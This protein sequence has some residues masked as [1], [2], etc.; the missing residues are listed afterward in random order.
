MVG[1]IITDSQKKKT[2]QNKEELDKNKNYNDIEKILMSSSLSSK[3]KL[4][5][6]L[7]RRTFRDETEKKILGDLVSFN[8][9]TICPECTKIIDIEQIC[10][11]HKN[12]RKDALWAKCPLCNKYILPQFSV[13]LGNNVN[14]INGD[15][16]VKVTRFVL[17]SP[18]ELKVK[19][20]ETID[21][22]GCPPGCRHPVYET[23]V[24][25]ISQIRKEGQHVEHYSQKRCPCRRDR[26]GKTAWFPLQG[27]VQFLWNPLC[28]GRKSSARHFRSDPEVRGELR[29]RR[30]PRYG[31]TRHRFPSA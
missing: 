28:K 7:Q 13:K 14:L 9:S 22:D 27:R 8:T 10:L 17:H 20:K 29:V 2:N 4:D 5:F 26:Q 25:D 16:C 19:I 31:G 12:M 30:G 15:D 1:K 18:Y 23:W 3:N 11:D 21:K 24:N 6:E